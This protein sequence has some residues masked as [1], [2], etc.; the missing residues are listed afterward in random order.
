MRRPPK[1][2]GILQ[3]RPTLPRPWLSSVK[4]WSRPHRRR[5]PRRVPDIVKLIHRAANRQPTRHPARQP[6][7]RQG[8]C[9]AES[10]REEVEERPKGGNS[11]AWR[12]RDGRRSPERGRLTW[13]WDARGRSVPRGCRQVRAREW[14]RT[15]N[16]RSEPDRLGSTQ[17]RSQD[18]NEALD[19]GKG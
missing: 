15:G 11:T 4:S 13:R 8:S 10:D 12:R 1:R 7:M 5:P 19:R 14:S 3:R 9:P 6:K 2:N 16:R 17:H 18:R